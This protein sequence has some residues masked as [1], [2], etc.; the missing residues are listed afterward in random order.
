MYMYIQVLHE[1]STCGHTTNQ[2]Y[3]VHWNCHE[4]QSLQQF[5]TKASFNVE[6][7]ETRSFRDGR[8]LVFGWRADKN[9]KPLIMVS[10]GCSE[11]PVF[12][13]TRRGGETVSK[14][15]VVNSYNHSMN[16]ALSSSK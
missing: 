2:L 8:M 11:K 7:G 14:P 3:L 16:G 1:Y 13:N 6:A 5:G 12:L 4:E 10:S 15:A 9:K